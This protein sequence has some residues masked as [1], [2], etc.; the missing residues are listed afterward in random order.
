MEPRKEKFKKK[1]LSRGEK[2]SIL[3]AIVQIVIGILQLL[4]G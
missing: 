2:I 4:K 3:L 1:P